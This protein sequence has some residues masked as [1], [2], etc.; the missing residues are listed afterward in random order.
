MELFVDNIYVSHEN[1]PFHYKNNKD[2]RQTFVTGPDMVFMVKFELF[3]LELD[4][5]TA[6]CADYLKFQIGWKKPFQLKFKGL[7]KRQ[8]KG[9]KIFKWLIIGFFRVWKFLKTLLT[10]LIDLCMKTFRVDSIF[11][12]SKFF[13]PK[14]NFCPENFLTLKNFSHLKNFFSPL[15]INSGKNWYQNSSCWKNF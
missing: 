6:A 12:P 1:F 8:N 5:T 7:P 13:N 9:F 14:G 10:N 2:R 4:R 15:M 3:H 11:Y